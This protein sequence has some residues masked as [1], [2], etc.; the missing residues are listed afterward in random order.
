MEEYYGVSP[1]ADFFMHY[2]IKGMKWGV[3]RLQKYRFGNPA[4]RK[5]YQETV[6]GKKR[7]GSMAHTWRAQ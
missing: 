3:R 1:H 2:G 4:E 7:L 5:R 6:P